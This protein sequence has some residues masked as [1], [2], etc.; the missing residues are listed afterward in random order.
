MATIL[1]IMQALG[2]NSGGEGGSNGPT[3]LVQF[4]VEGCCENI[5]CCASHV[6][7]TNKKKIKSNRRM[8][9]SPPSTK[10]EGAQGTLSPEQKK[11]S[12]QL[13]FCCNCCV[14]SHIKKQQNIEA[15]KNFVTH[16]ISSHGE[17]ATQVA[18]QL[19]SAQKN[20]DWHTQK[21]QQKAL[22]KGD[23]LELIEQT[24]LIE[25]RLKSSEFYKQLLE[26]ME[27]VNEPLAKKM[28]AGSLSLNDGSTLKDGIKG[29]EE[30]EKVVPPL[31]LEGR[32]IAAAAEELEPVGIAAA[33]EEKD[34]LSTKISPKRNG[35]P[36]H[37]GKIK[38]ELTV[39][40]PSNLTEVFNNPKRLSPKDC[41]K[42]YDAIMQKDISIK[43]VIDLESKEPEEEIVELI[44]V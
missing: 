11:F 44:E 10:D 28:K 19:F 18:I 42:L 33:A 40:V 21:Q 30:D 17:I 4:D 23:M 13:I 36:L 16:L 38:R 14:G 20:I 31:L 39:H 32:E 5:V 3:V 15:K 7:Q 24:Q 22:T 29:L 8:I 35:Q 1:P 34:P 27:F 41:T 2:V 6:K 25:S 43:T 12:L 9:Y 37:S 26:M